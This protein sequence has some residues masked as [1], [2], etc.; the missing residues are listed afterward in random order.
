MGDTNNNAEAV[1]KYHKQIKDMKIRFPRANK[2]LGI[3]DYAEII[4]NQAGLLGK[5]ST[6]NYILDLIEE[7]IRTNPAGILNK[8][9]KINR[10]LKALK[11]V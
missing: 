4:K 7:D 9:F 11:E 8:E 6:N 2:D 5:S 3:P 1:S 10:D